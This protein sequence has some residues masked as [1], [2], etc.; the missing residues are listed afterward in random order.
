MV[1]SSVI[2]ELS[3]RFEL[4]LAL[5]LKALL[6]RIFS[7]KVPW[8]YESARLTVQVW[9]SLEIVEES[10]AAR[11]ERGVLKLFRVVQRCYKGKGVNLGRRLE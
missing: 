1:V 2:G 4:Y 11:I 3:Q 9:C 5:L 7:P 8:G 10:S 6:S